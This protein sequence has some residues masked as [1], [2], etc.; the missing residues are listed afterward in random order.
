MTSLN[1]RLFL[2]ILLALVL[3]IIPLPELLIGIRPP[4]VLLLALYLEFYMPDEFSIVLLLTVGLVLDVL[5]S[6]VLG[7]HAFALSL[8]T[9]IANSK[10]RRFSLFTIGQQMALIG[11]FC[12]VYQLIILIIDGSLGYKTGFL[13]PIGSALISVLL[14]PWVRLVADDSLFSKVVY[15]R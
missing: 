14:W 4:W 7:E 8:V 15:R 12:L 13:M 6:T 5:L 9:W 2:A 3:T 11:F 10:A 1:L